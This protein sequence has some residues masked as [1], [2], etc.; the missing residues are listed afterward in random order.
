MLVLVG[1]GGGGDSG[2]GGGG[3]PVTYRSETPHLRVCVSRGAAKSPPEPAGNRLTARLTL[4]LSFCDFSIFLSF[5]QEEA[6]V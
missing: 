6:I 1:D 5:A 4:S 2:G 3:D